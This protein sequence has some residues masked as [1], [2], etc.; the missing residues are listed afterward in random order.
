MTTRTFLKQF[1]AAGLCAGFLGGC[2]DR[3]TELHIGITCNLKPWCYL[4]SKEGLFTGFD[5]ELAR[6]VCARLK[7]QPIFH[8]IMWSEKERLIAARKIDCVWSSFTITGREDYFTVLGPYA[9]NANLVVTRSDTGI[10]KNAALAGRTVLVQSGSSSE[11]SLKPGGVAAELGA[12]IGC[13][14]TSPYVGV[15]VQR[16]RD[17]L[18]DA[19]IL[20]EDVARAVIQESGGQF[21]LVPDEPLAQEGLGIG[22]HLGDTELCACIAKVLHQLE[23]EGVCAELSLRFFGHPNRFHF[24]GGQE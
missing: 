4:D 16:L 3:R 13:L 12:R 11:T 17:G 8:S 21:V 18:G 24:P 6:I 14:L 7:W 1:V 20:D 22:F 10:K 5:V 15:C 23:E 19:L 9:S 2:K